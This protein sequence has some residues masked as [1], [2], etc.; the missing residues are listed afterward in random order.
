MGNRNIAMKS[1]ALGP[2]FAE[3]FMTDSG[4]GPW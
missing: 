4:L 1:V 3:E 2:S